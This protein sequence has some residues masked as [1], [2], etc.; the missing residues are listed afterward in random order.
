M[1]VQFLFMGFLPPVKAGEFA[2]HLKADIQKLGRS[3]QCQ[4]KSK[5]PFLP[6]R[7][8]IASPKASP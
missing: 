8:T 7:S 1:W 4:H 2:R 5:W 3:S 6:L